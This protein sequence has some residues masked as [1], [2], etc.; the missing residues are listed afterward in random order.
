MLVEEKISKEIIQNIDKGNVKTKKDLE[1]FK[2][3]LSM[4]YK[5]KHM[6]TS[7]DITKYMSDEKITKFSEIM[8]IKPTRTI[9]GVATITI[10]CKPGP[11]GG[12]CTYCLPATKITP[13][14]YSPLEPAIQRAIRNEFDPTRQIRDRLNQYKI[15]GHPNDKIEI[16][17]IGG[18]FLALE[19]DYKEWFIKDIYDGLNGFESGDLQQAIK[20]NESANHRCIGLTIETRPDYCFE[21]HVDEMLNYGATRIELGVQSIY[22]DVLLKINRGHGVEENIKAIRI[23]KDAGYKIVAHI[24]PFLPGSDFK[25]ELKMFNILF[26]NPNFMPDDYKI[27]PTMV[28]PNTILYEEWMNGNYTPPTDEDVKNLFVEIK[29]MVPPFVRFRRMLRDMPATEI[30]SGPKKSNIREIALQELKNQGLKCRCTRCRE[31]GHAKRLH[32]IEPNIENIELIRR[33][34]DASE[35]KEIFLSFEDTKNDILIALARLRVPSEKTHRK[36][37]KKVASVIRELHTY[38][39]L[40]PIDKQPKNE[41]QHRGYGKELISE[42]EKISKEE[43]DRKKLVIISGV[44]VKKYFTKLGYSY[45]GPYMSKFLNK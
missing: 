16:I 27:Y 5:L 15:M 23:A 44:G 38:G 30:A 43:F 2:K 36:E 10:S 18:T 33:D 13:K 35:G 19:K 32:N 45:D 39:P 21:P 9:S 41:W 28:M 40:V 7:P 37:I 42:A 34:Y 14:S 17:I 25:R 11:C 26:T 31:P 6:I 22:N 29:K 3:Q 8:H 4:K 20:K 1:K 12:A 24:M